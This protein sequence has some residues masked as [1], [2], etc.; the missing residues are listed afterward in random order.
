MSGSFAVSD[1]ASLADAGEVS[2]A[3]ESLVQAAFPA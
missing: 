1:V 2:F 3:E